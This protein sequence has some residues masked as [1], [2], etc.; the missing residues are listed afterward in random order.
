MRNSRIKN[1]ILLQRR[2]LD[3]QLL[4][5]FYEA[6]ELL[7]IYSS[8]DGLLKCF[9][10]TNCPWECSLDFEKFYICKECADIGCVTCQGGNARTGLQTCPSCAHSVGVALTWPAAWRASIWVRSQWESNNLVSKSGVEV[11]L[12]GASGVHLVSAVHGGRLLLR[13]S[14]CNSPGTADTS[15]R[16]WKYRPRLVQDIIQYVY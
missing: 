5:D 3:P 15:G 1:L 12:L 6:W 10:V 16:D 4:T 14:V 9:V 7:R 11:N 2:H 8:C 13:I